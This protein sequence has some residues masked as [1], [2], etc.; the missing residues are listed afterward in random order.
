MTRDILL[1]V[2]NGLTIDTLQR[3]KFDKEFDCKK[4]FSWD[5]KCPSNPNKK[6]F[7]YKFLP[8]IRK[9]YKS[10]LDTRKTFKNHFENSFGFNDF[11][12]IEVSLSYFDKIYWKSEIDYCKDKFSRLNYIQNYSNPGINTLLREKIK[13]EIQF[14]HFINQAY[15][16]L[17]N[18]IENG[19]IFNKLETNFM[20]WIDRYKSNV[21]LI[22]S[23]NYD[24]TLENI[25][26]VLGIRF[27]RL[28]TADINYDNGIP[29]WKPHGSI[30]FYQK[31]WV[32]R[33]L[34]PLKSSWY[35]N[36]SD[37]TDILPKNDWM[38]PRNQVDIVLPTQ[39]S[40]TFCYSFNISGWDR[41][42]QQK[43]GISEIFYYGLS[44]DYPDRNEIDGLLSI[45][46][47]WKIRIINPSPPGAFIAK[48]SSLGY[49][50]NINNKFKV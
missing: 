27:Y 10:V 36:Y 39:K 2:G 46:K 7:Q 11:D 9:Y 15:V 40:D 45:S 4:I 28:G 43:N 23:Y 38:M 14:E 30:D 1:I 21:A 41:F 25:L 12:V 42:N 13:Y 5:V 47:K 34:Y 18:T 22:I 32:K 16:L 17:Q 33:I 24:L 20:T 44:Y 50:I 48:Y 37:K 35:R 8:D 29:I 3:S 49:E 31:V 26:E 19:N 6:F